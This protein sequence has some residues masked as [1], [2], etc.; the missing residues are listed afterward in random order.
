MTSGLQENQ[1][2]TSR[3]SIRP[4]VHYDRLIRSCWKRNAAGIAAYF[5]KLCYTGSEGRIT[6]ST[7]WT[8]TYNISHQ[9]SHDERKTLVVISEARRS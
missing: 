1:V 8:A 4:N 5:A 2:Q 9:F 6:K 7:Y 3:S